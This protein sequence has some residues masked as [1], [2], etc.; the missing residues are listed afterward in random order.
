MNARNQQTISL[1]RRLAAMGYD[2]LL[3]SAVIIV[4]TA[5]VVIIAGGAQN[6]WLGSSLY[7]L[8]LLLVSFV[9]LGWF[10][11]HGGQTLGLRSWKAKVIRDDG[12]PLGWREALIRFIFS[13]F[14][15]ALFGIGF[16]WILFDPEKLAWHDRLSGTRI[17]Y[18]DHKTEEKPQSIQ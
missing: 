8:Y 1:I 14:S 13:T 7:T 10:W 4:S 2:A 17:I 11:T 15:L 3:W 9:F 6:P 12:Y 5:P 18:Y 16:I